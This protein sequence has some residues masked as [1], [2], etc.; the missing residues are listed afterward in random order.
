MFWM[1]KGLRLR[2]ISNVN[3][4]QLKSN[5]LMLCQNLQCGLIRDGQSSMEGS[6]GKELLGRSCQFFLVWATHSTY[7]ALHTV[8]N[9]H[10]IL[11]ILGTA[12]CMY[13]LGTAQCTYWA[14]HTAH[15][16]LLTVRCSDCTQFGTILQ[17]LLTQ[18]ATTITIMKSLQSFGCCFCVCS[19]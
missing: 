9:G 8:H 19:V 12:H 5:M 17:I 10:C 11:Y 3:S 18:L 2:P 15:S 16:R 4:D 1:K 6:K 14:L 7:W 13:I